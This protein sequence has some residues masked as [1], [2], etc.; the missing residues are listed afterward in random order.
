MALADQ[1]HK[2]P[3]EIRDM[4]IE[5]AVSMLAFYKMRG[6]KRGH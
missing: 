2:M 6:A 3:S 1:L 5:D 4:P